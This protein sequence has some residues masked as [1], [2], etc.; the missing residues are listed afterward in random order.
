[1]A[2]RVVLT[3]LTVGVFASMATAQ[4]IQDLYTIYNPVSAYHPS[5]DTAAYFSPFGAIKPGTHYN[6]SMGTGY[7]SFGSGMGLSS[8]YIAP[9]VSIAP[10]EKLQLV[11]GANFSYTSFN[12]IPFQKSTEVDSKYTTPGGNPTQAWAYGQYNFNNRFS[13]YAMGSFAKN[14]LYFSPYQAG[15]GTSD[16]NSVGVG[17]NY[18]IG[19]NAS[20]GASFNFSNAPNYFGVSPVSNYNRWM[21]P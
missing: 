8:S 1:M 16:Y 9:Q 15:I 17:F 7:S 3:F 12:N 19:K 20:I 10:N 13:V 2:K 21:F 4:L 6:F 11:V 5:Y 14:Q 18:R